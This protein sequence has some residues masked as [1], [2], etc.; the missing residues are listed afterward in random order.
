[1]ARRQRR[2]FSASF[3]AKVALAA[4]KGDKTLSELASQFDVHP[5]VIAQWKRQLLENAD[6]L[7]SK[8]ASERGDH[9]GEI[10]ELHA[11]IGQLTMERDFLAVGLARTGGPGARR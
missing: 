3:K 8:S 10:K 11:K 2:T 9:E 1:M 7:F 6:A 5:N 4:V